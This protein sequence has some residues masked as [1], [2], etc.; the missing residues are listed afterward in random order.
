MVAAYHGHKIDLNGLRQRF[1]LSLKGATIS[2]LIVVASALDLGCRPL[3]LELE[4]M[5]Q[6]AVP[7]ILHWDLNHFVVLKSVDRTGAAVIHDP[8]RGIR[9]ITKAELS[10]HFSGVAMEISPAADF[11]SKEIRARVRLSDLWSRLL[12]W[13]RAVVQTLLLSALLQMFALAA[14][15]YLQLAIDE[16]ILRVDD[17]FLVVLALAFGAM[18][19]IQSCTEALRGWVVLHL[20]QAIGFQIIG[21]VLHHLLRLPTEF[22]EKRI[23]GDILSRMGSVRPIQQALAQSM[24]TAVIDGLMALTTGIVLFAYSALLGAIVVGSVLFYWT[25]VLLLFPYRRLKEEE[26]IVSHAEAQTYLIESIR[27]SKTVKLFGREAQREVVFRN[28]F[29]NVVRASIESSKVEVASISLRALVFGLQIVGVVYVASTMVM[30]GEFTVGMLFALMLY[31]S[32][33]TER[34][35]TLVQRINE[36]RLL[37]MHLDRLADIVH[38]KPEAGL[39][40]AR[41]QGQEVAGAIE[42]REVGYRYAPNEPLIFDKVSLTIRSGEFVAI[43][44]P[45]GGGKTTLLKVM[46]GLLP[47]T[48]GD[49]LVEGQPMKSFG[50]AQW[51]STIGVVQQDD[52]LLMGTLADNIAFFDAE[53]DMQRVITSAKAAAVH[54]EI[55]AMPMGYLSLVGDMGST[56]SG[57]Q[58]QRVLLARALY[59][60]PRLLFLDEGTANLDAETELRVADLVE[61][62]SI[63]RVVIAHRPEL[64]R[65][66]ERVFEMRNGRLL[67]CEG[68]GVAPHRDARPAEYRLAIAPSGE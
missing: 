26:Q 13:K 22:F 32:N 37:R 4:Q 50:I 61:K 11:K 51:R 27:A 16:A 31:R 3:R 65:R 57:G 28:Y 68:G 67:Q 17:Q 25:I 24:V 54:D 2:D 42:L 29:A 30:R 56:L 39:D 5:K 47:A 55:L 43:V 49:V 59:R 10:K 35:D 20:S 63:T 45:S 21:N 46:L 62:M 34:A 60:Q 52:G 18:Y 66:A 53:L 19:V 58:R 9:K 6:L 15:S 64:V 7:C 38:S 44:G 36:F 41:V 12:G 48:A 23:V 33:F 14:P 1:A 40:E 8:A